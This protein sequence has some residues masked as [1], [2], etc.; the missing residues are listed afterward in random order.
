MA[1]VAARFTSASHLWLGFSLGLAPV[2]AWIAVT[3]RLDWPPL[4]LSLAVTLWVAGFDVIYSLQ[5]EA[6]D[7]SHGLRSLPSTVGGRRALATARHF[8]LGAVVGFALFADL[9]GGGWLRIL[10]VAS[11]G[12]LLL[13]QHLIVAA[14]D[15]RSVGAAFF[16]PNGFLPLLMCLLFLVA[17][18]LDV[19][20]P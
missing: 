4:V 13:W 6:F 5:D 9:A 7:R 15:R 3:E 18:Y 12:L 17:K 19:S 20:A 2:G 8:H 11:A 1:A 10:A 14:D 16:A